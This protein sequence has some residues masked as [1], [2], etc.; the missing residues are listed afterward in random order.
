VSESRSQSCSRLVVARNESSS[1]DNHGQARQPAIWIPAHLDWSCQTIYPM[2]MPPYAIQPEDKAAKAREFPTPAAANLTVSTSFPHLNMTAA[3]MHTPSATSPFLTQDR[4]TLPPLVRLHS[5]YPIEGSGPPLPSP[6]GS[7]AHSG[8]NA[9][10][11][12]SFRA[13]SWIQNPT[14]VL[15]VQR[16]PHDLPLRHSDAGL[17]PTDA[18]PS[19]IG[20]S[21]GHNVLK[22]PYDAIRSGDERLGLISRGTSYL[23]ESRPSRYQAPVITPL[24]PDPRDPTLR[25]LPIPFAP[26]ARS[27]L[28][29]ASTP[30]G[31]LTSHPP[32]GQTGAFSR[33]H[34]ISSASSNSHRCSLFIR[35]Q[36]RAA[37]AGPDGKDRR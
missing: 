15:T 2:G 21:H 32:T 37:R 26:S 24:P 20:S 1:S 29:D 34:S 11:S 9:S 18:Q 13:N 5:L 31:T 28:S 16:H 30:A 19:P 7:F 3:A 33:T 17:Y 27:S 12:A 35:Q 25:V 36:P 8:H 6:A 4:L 23:T 14:P 22:R 10:P